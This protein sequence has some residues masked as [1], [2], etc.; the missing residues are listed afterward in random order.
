MLQ[1]GY[2]FKPTDPYVIIINIKFTSRWFQS[3]IFQYKIKGKED[4]TVRKFKTRTAGIYIYIDSVFLC[5]HRA[6]GERIKN[7]E[8]SFMANNLSTED[9]SFAPSCFHL[10]DPDFD[11]VFER[12]TMNLVT[13]IINIIASPLAVISNS[14]IVITI[15]SS[16]R[17]R[18][19]S[20]LF[21]GCLAL[22]DVF[23][24]LTVQP[25]YISFRLME[26]QHRSVPCFVRVMY[27]NT[28]FVCCGVSF[29]TLSAVTYER[30]VAVRLR[31]RYNDVFTAQRV[32][33]FMMAIWILNI[34][35][36]S[37]QWAGLSHIS[38]GI[39]YI[40]WFLCLLG[41]VLA[42][43]RIGFILR[44]HHHQLQPHSTISEDIR[45]QREFKL[46][47]NILFIV[48]VYLLFNM[49]LLLL[50]MYRQ[51]LQQDIKTY[52]HYSWTETLSFL[53]SCTNPL[54]CYWK[55]SQIRHGVLAI[56]ERVT[57]RL[58]GGGETDI[59]GPKYNNTR[60]T[61]NTEVSLGE[62]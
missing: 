35:L 57:R 6:V 54:L 47:R 19:P 7:S 32:L 25:G 43:I 27:S 20:N 46:T 44:R 21:I 1:K 11:K 36:T 58:F 15:F 16:S 40:V 10:P 37:L 3:E 4:I 59:R 24:G 8:S 52:N 45:K 31:A 34:I 30:L 29:M 55:S 23:V 9:L 61:A 42:N 14:L 38:K 53:N 13:A 49:P 22:S 33:K 39:H 26:N 17:L 5:I 50:K 51:I 56:P 2:C 41:S 28:F 62:Q 18:T 12:F 48:G 60:F